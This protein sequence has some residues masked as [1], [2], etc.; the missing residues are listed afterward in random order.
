MIRLFVSVIAGFATW[1]VLWLGTN[2]GL[3][4]LVPTWYETEKLA[5]RPSLLALVVSALLSLLAGYI[6][7][8]IA[9]VWRPVIILACVQ[10]LV[11]ALVSISYWSTLPL[12]YHIS[13]LVLLFPLHILGAKLSLS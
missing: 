2:A 11:G 5:A 3:R 6:T 9:G 13:F 7:A 12:W 10:V 1:T 4:N 8:T